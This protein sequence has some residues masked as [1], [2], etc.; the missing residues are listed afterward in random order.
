M[1]DS[2]AEVTARCKA[3]VEDVRLMM[4]GLGSVMQMNGDGWR[5]YLTVMLDGLRA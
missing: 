3:E 4:C 2:Q 5:R 1:E